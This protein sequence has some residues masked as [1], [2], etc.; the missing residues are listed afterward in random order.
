VNT[1]SSSSYPYEPDLAQDEALPARPA[2]WTKP[3]LIAAV[4]TLGLLLRLWAAWQLPVDAD[5]PVYLQA[6]YDYARLLRAG[7]V[8][9]IIDYRGNAEHPPLGKLFIALALLPFGS[10]PDWFMGLLA[11]RLASVLFGTLA[12]LLAALINPA[13]GLALAVQTMV[14]KYTSEVYLEAVPLF[15]SLAAVFCLLRVPTADER[16]ARSPWLWLS[17]AALGMAGAG[18]YAYLPIL[19]VLV[20]IFLGPKRLSWKLLLP[21]LLLAGAAFWALNPALWRDPIGRLLESLTFHTQYSQSQHVQDWAYPWWQPFVWVTRSMPY[22]WHPDV[23]FYFGFDGLIAFLAALGLKLNWQERR[24]VVVWIIAGLLFLIV[25]PTKW[26]Q[27]SLVVQPAVCL[28]AGFGFNFLHARL[29]E[30]DMYWNW[31]G[32]MFIRPSRLLVFSTIALITIVLL[33]GVM[34]NARRAW[35]S[36]GWYELNALNTPLPSDTVYAILILPERQIALAVEGGAARM[37]LSPDSGLPQDWEIFTPANSGLPSTRVLDLAQDAQGGLWFATL[38]GLAHLDGDSWRTYRGAE[39]GLAADSVQNVEIDSQGRVWAATRAGMAVYDGHSWQAFT[40]ASSDL[41]GD[42][43]TSLAVLPHPSGE[44]VWAATAQGVTQMVLAEAGSGP[45]LVREW[46]TFSMAELGIGS[47]GISRLTVDSL[48]GVW[49]ATY[50]YGLLRW[51]GQAWESLRVS[52]S[53]LPSNTV[54]AIFEVRPGLYYVATANPTEVGGVLARY[55]GQNWDRY[56]PSNSGFTGAEPL[57]AALD[58]DGR[59]WVGTRTGGISIYQRP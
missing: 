43:V 55:D 38:G 42:A 14:V 56:T 3:R 36:R 8:Q 40:S 24:W 54:T 59:L 15:A 57:A 45:P 27:Y 37:S 20:Y 10:E 26:P 1:P 18:K 47:G 35:I 33:G 50:G 51:D 9:G 30:A 2:F 22:E 34:V 6:G 21:Y 31:L 41:P 17:A 16:A 53:P 28:S 5:E 46:R 44:Q 7:D 32:E 12:V 49:V 13:A 48:G 52:N 58:H 23:F 4:V 19:F 11:G 25:W 29:R 39:L